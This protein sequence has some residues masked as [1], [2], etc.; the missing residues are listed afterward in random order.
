MSEKNNV[1]VKFVKSWRGYN[2]EEVA[3]FPADQA[4]KL[5]EGGV[6]EKHGGAATGRGTARAAANGGGGGR[7]K[8]APAADDSA[9]AAK[10]SQQGGS[11]GEGGGTPNPDDERP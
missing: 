10:G 6:A 11:G 2:P 1:A 3:G 4:Q 5:I 8:A 7:G 9:A